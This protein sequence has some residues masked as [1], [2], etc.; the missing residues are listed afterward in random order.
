MFIPAFV[1][2]GVVAAIPWCSVYEV[3]VTIHFMKGF[4]L[5]F[6]DAGECLFDYAFLFIII[7]TNKR[8]IVNVLESWS[9]L[10]YFS[11]SLCKK[12]CTPMNL[13]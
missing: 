6:I 1:L 12:K 5:G 4:C 13:F 8:Q 3:M 9:D 11:F 2:S 10:F 7:I